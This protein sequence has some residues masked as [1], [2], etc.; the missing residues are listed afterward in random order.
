MRRLIGI[1]WN[2]CLKSRFFSA[3]SKFVLMLFILLLFLCFGPE[4][5]DVGDRLVVVVFLA[6]VEFL[7]LPFCPLLLFTATFVLRLVIA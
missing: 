6:L 4:R 2:W 1:I 3:S 5:L 7:L